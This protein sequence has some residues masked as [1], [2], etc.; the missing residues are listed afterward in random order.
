MRRTLIII[1][2][3]IIL[4]GAGYLIWNQTQTSQDTVTE[5]LREQVVERG[6]IT[7]TVSATGA[8]EPEALVSLTF[9]LAGTVQ[10]VN[11][12]RGQQV[13][14]GQVLATLNAEELA[15]AVQQAEDALAIQQL[16]LAQ[17]QNRTPS[18]ARL[19][20]ADADIAAAEANV[21]VSEGSLEAAIA[22]VQQAEAQKAQLLAGPTAAEIAAAEADLSAARLDQ[23]QWQDRY[24]QLI[25][26]EILGW[27]EEEAR[28]AL[29]ASNKRLVAAEARL[30]ALRNGPRLA[31]I[32]VVDAAIA[33]AQAQVTSAEGNVAAAEANLARARAA[34]DLLA[35]PATEDELAVLEAQVRSAETNLEIARLR[36]EQSQVV[37]P[38]DGTVATVATNAGE[39][40]TP[41]VPVITVVNED[42]FH[43]TVNVDEIDIDRIAVGQPVDITLDALPEE[44][45][46]G[47][48]SDIAPTPSSA[49][50][51][52]TYLVTINITEFGDLNLRPGMSANASVVVDEVDDVLTV[53]NWAIRL[54]RETGEAFVNIERNDGTVEEVP[55]T[56]GLRNEQF[57]EIL[58]G[59]SAGDVVVVTSEREELF[60]FFGGN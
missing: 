21:T 41:G 8:I 60:S 14:A 43:I 48:I 57:S 49:T 56:T 23:K 20:T 52:V 3:V 51:I 6:R 46:T 54:D 42:A 33:A 45:V 26:N 15:L 53:P 40:V 58:S 31:D 55:V 22:A 47:T 44:Q 24:D 9:G 18:A 32:Q 37:A 59:L 12:T 25:Q 17:A 19:A 39:Q 29:D 50:G 4:A 5:I 1:L 2:V 35:E 27:P 10:Q 38:I 11:V 16:T 28:Q 30:E 13:T 34:A 7:A 36:L